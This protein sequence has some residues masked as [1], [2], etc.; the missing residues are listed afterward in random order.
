MS[1]LRHSDGPTHELVGQV[2]SFENRRFRI[3]RIIGE[4]GF[5]FV[6]MATD[7]NTG[8]VYALK[9]GISVRPL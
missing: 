1:Y 2:V 7:L 9:Y 5:A 4:G 3:E 6:F 8:A